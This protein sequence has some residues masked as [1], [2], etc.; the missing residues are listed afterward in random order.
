MEKTISIAGNANTVN[1]GSDRQTEARPF[2]QNIDT[3]AIR[4]QTYCFT[5]VCYK[6]RSK[7]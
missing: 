2:T 5:S 6:I 3:L 7:S 4:K 1:W